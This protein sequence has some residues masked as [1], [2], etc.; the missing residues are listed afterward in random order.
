MSSVDV[1][2]DGNRVWSIDLREQN[3]VDGHL[4]IEWP[5]SL[6]PHLVGETILGVSDSRTGRTILEEP[7]TFDS[8]GT[9]TRV[10]DEAGTQ[11]AVNK[12]GRLAPTLESLGADVQGLIVDRALQIVTILESM[13]L[14]PFAV[15]GT[16]LGAVRES[17]LLPH[18]DDADIAYLSEFTEPVD[19][20]IEAF[21]VGRELKEA[22]YE[23][24]RHSATH[25]QLIFRESDGQIQHYID[26]F[27]A[28]FTDDGLVNQPFHVRGPMRRDQMLPFSLVQI[29]GTEFPA[30]SDTDHWLTIN[31]D[32]NWRQPIPGYEIVTPEPTRKRFDAWFGGFN[33]QREFWDEWYLSVDAAVRDGQWESGAAWIAEQSFE[34]PSLLDLG[35]GS[36]LQSARLESPGRR[37]IACDYS[38]EALRRAEDGGRETAHV[39]L[40]RLNALAVPSELGLGGPF[41]IV[42]NHLL[43]QVGHIARGNALRL[44]RMALRSGGKAVATSYSAPAPEIDNL[45]PTTWHL[46]KHQ[47]RIAAREYGLEVEF[48]DIEALP[49]ESP[50]MP[51]GARFS[52][53]LHPYK[54]K[55]PSMK[56]RLK[57]LLRRARTSDTKLELET[58]RTRVDE[59]E[60]EL[61]EVRRDNLRVS[62]LIDLAE[63]ALTPQAPTPK[64]TPPQAPTPPKG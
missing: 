20:G 12:W 40:N 60:T 13:G 29:D 7:V 57:R 4:S 43:E 61:E 2:F 49:G 46:E 39:N 41:D 47:L 26:V 53:G 50:R 3:P 25:M 34:S 9:R 6:L 33:F 23:L 24:R 15:G 21:R 64:A 42:A 36:G 35:S 11:L 37:V 51:Y 10:I 17:A 14:R 16:L 8:S 45:D 56:Q 52:L 54:R 59:L 27:A 32:E 62:E 58:L 30:P 44:I 63:Q 38:P 28:F 5:E 19:V 31:Y 55:E 22:G 1:T 18:D 48:F